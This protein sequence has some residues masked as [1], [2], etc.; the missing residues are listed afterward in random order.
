MS[1][2]TEETIWVRFFCLFERQTIL[3]P[4]GY[5]L[6]TSSQNPQ[7]AETLILLGKYSK[8]SKII[9]KD[10]HEPIT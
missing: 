7:T 3:Y 1:K 5:T 6:Q 2:C 4:N 8:H 10:T 9:K